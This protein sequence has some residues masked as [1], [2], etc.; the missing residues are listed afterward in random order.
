MFQFIL[1][2]SDWILIKQIIVFSTPFCCCGEIDFQKILPGVLSGEWG[3]DITK[4]CKIYTKTDSWFQ[5][6]HEEF[7]QFQTSSGK[8]KKLKFDG[9]F[10][11]KKYIPSA[12]T[13]YTEELS[14]LLS[15]N[16]SSNSFCHL[17]NHKSFFTT[18]LLCIFLAQTLDTFDKSSPSKCKFS[19]FPLLVLKFTKFRMSCHFSNKKLVFL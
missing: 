11:S 4:W 16:C 7:G 12:K 9:I 17:W 18:Q 6:S 13:L 1:I 10:L 3:Q 2:F 19:D 5:K 15:T 8:S 14:T